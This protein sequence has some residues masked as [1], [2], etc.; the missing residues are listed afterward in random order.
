[1]RKAL[2]ITNYTDETDEDL[3]GISSAVIKGCTN[4]TNFIFADNELTELMTANTD[5]VHKAGLAETGN[6]ASISLKRLAKKVLALALKTVCKEINHQQKGNEAI[7]KTCGA[8]MSKNSNT[9]KLGLLPVA[10]NLTGKCGS[11]LFELIVKVKKIKGLNNNGTV[12]AFTEMDNASDDIST[13]KKEH[14]SCHSMTLTGLKKATMYLVSAAYKGTTNT[15]LNW[16]TTI[17]VATK[18]G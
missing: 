11:Q 9:H 8:T 12:F 18:A 4:N 6:K 14:S 15:P 1:M 3:T 2:V 5:F 17:I 10:Q 7:L 16:C 13:W